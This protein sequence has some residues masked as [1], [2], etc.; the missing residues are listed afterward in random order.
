MIEI[1]GEKYYSKDE[2]KQLIEL[3]EM[4][5]NSDFKEKL[6]KMK[7]RMLPDE[8]FMFHSK[9]NTTVKFKSGNSITVRRMKG[10]EDSVEVAL[11]FILA[12]QNYGKK[13]F[14]RLVKK[15]KEVRN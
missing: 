6:E 9:R 4:S 14:K 11:A 5:S 12:F 15:F 10:E 1:N 2:V 3:S 7:D 8:N 13:G